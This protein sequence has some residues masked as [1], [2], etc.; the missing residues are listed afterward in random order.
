MNNAVYRP[1]SPFGGL[2]RNLSRIF[3]ERLFPVSEATSSDA[4]DW[5]PR[6]DVREEE[7]A[8]VVQADVPGVDAKDI[9]ITLDK[10]KLAIRGSRNSET[11]TKEDGYTR[12]ER[13]TGNFVRQF[14]LPETA[15]GERITAKT[16]N[17]VLTIEIP[18]TI[19]S[20]PR[21]IEVRSES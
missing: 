2:N 15:D 12:K 1:I 17:G 19:V 6:V 16:T 10:N 20:Q 3:D 4:T 18:K 11:E 7:N 13:F 5:V 21:S 8:F 14:S 9:D